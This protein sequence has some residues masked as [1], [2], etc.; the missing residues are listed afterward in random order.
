MAPA[1]SR[2]DGRNRTSGS[3]R[4]RTGR[5]LSTSEETSPR[6]PARPGNGARTEAP[7][8]SAAR[9]DEEREYERAKEILLRQLTHSAKS[10]AQLAQK[11]TEREVPEATA[12][13]ILD[14]YQELGLIDDREFAEMFVRSRAASRKLARPALRRELERKG[15]DPDTAEAALAQRD[16]EQELQD[17]RE[18][19][20]KKI[21]PATDLRDAQTRD[22]ALRR[23]VA[24]LARRGHAPG[25]AFHVA[26]EELDA[27]GTAAEPNDGE[28]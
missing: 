15:I 26:R 22:K 6:A 14:R 5:R 9:T 23:L 2:G 1:A 11:L 21:R 7:A 19:V 17:A 18:L 28:A 3:G 8:A 13:R 24:M 12:Q 16:D 27:A 25:T 4:R 20:R 10:R